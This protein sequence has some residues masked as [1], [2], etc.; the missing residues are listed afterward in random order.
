MF[1]EDTE[2]AYKHISVKAFVAMIGD[3]M[4]DE[5]FEDIFEKVFDTTLGEDL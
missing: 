5:G 3:T 4:F 2:N 1:Y